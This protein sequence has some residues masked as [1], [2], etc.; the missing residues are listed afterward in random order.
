MLPT[1]LGFKFNPFFC[2]LLPLTMHGKRSLELAG[3]H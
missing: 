2:A 3:P 1:K